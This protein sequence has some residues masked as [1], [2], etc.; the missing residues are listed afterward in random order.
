MD[1]FEKYLKE[2]EHSKWVKR[3][4]TDRSYK[5]VFQESF[6]IKYEEEVWLTI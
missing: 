5:K 4:L 3:A 6:S 1:L 2:K